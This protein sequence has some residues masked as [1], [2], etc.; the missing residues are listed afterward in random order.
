MAV[1]AGL[2][3]IHTL[4]RLINAGDAPKKITG[5]FSGTLGFVMTALQNGQSYSAAVKY[6]T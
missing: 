5:T 1:C 2:P 4:T 6:T 3:V